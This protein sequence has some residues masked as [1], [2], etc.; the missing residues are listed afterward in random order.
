MALASAGGVADD[1]ADDGGVVV[2]AAIVAVGT[3]VGVAIGEDGA[4]AQAEA[5]KTIAINQ[6]RKAC[7]ASRILCA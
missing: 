6:Q 2:A 5:S 7:Q 3:R 4:V 1:E